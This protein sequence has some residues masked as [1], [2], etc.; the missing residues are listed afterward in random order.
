MPLHADIMVRTRKLGLDSLTPIL[1]FNIANGEL[2]ADGNGAVFYG[3]PYQPGA[4]VK[5]RL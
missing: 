3:K 2:E 4:I 1:W 5:K